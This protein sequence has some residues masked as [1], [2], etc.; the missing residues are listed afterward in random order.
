MMIALIALITFAIITKLYYSG[1]R[2]NNRPYIITLEGAKFKGGSNEF[3]S[4]RHTV[5][6]R[7][8]STSRLA[9]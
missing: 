2:N 5:N 7:V 8:R 1:L 4:V 9:A 3:K 6:P